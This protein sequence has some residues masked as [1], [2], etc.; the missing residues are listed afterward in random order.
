MN[1]NSKSTKEL[2]CFAFLI[3]FLIPWTS[4]L[5]NSNLIG[6]CN[7]DLKQSFAPFFYCPCSLDKF[8]PILNLLKPFINFNEASLWMQR[9]AKKSEL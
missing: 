9:G 5:V 2:H 3:F 6:M 8:R 7:R 1:F 4:C